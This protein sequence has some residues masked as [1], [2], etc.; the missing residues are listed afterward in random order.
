MSFTAFLQEYRRLAIL[1]VLAEGGYSANESLITD[2]VRSYG[3]AATRDQVRGEL[4]WL[5]EQQLVTTSEVAHLLIATITERGLDVAHGR[6]L[7]PGV[8]RP[9]PGA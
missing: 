1:R 3:V 4:G 9:G 2:V 5:A 8:K 7:Y 6:A